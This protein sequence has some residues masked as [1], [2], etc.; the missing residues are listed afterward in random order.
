MMADGRR[1][2]VCVSGRVQ[3]VYFRSSTKQM[4]DS[5]GLTGW[6]RN[7]PDGRVEAVFEGDAEKVDKAIN[8]CSSGPE[9]AYVE[10]VEVSWEKHMRE[11]T[12]FEIEH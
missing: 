8:W 1:A 6:V 7:L 10:K 4:A 3:V 9:Y 5:L 11:F 2:H 12:S